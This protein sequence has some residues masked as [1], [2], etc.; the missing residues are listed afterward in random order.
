MFS[1]VLFATC[2]DAFDSEDI[3][4]VLPLIIFKSCQMNRFLKLWKTKEFFFLCHSLS[5]FLCLP[6]N[7]EDGDDTFFWNYGCY[8][9]HAST[10]QRT[11]N[12]AVRFPLACQSAV[13]SY[14]CYA[15]DACVLTVETVTLCHTPWHPQENGLCFPSATAKGARVE[16]TQTLS[17]PPRTVS[18]LSTTPP[19]PTSGFKWI[20]G[21]LLSFARVRIARLSPSVERTVCGTATITRAIWRGDR[22]LSTGVTRSDGHYS[23]FVQRP[24]VLQLWIGW[25]KPHAHLRM[26][27]S[28]SYIKILYVS[29]RKLLNDTYSISRL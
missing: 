3:S 16:L 6:S 1:H 26:R 5:D 19:S 13:C 2:L 15:H 29:F 24:E 21:V 11:S 4:S 23:G 22:Q 25:P 27:K 17:P 9:Q 18:Q 7:P 12:A 14:P 10:N 20:N 8:I 28:I